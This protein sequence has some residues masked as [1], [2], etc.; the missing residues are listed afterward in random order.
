MFLFEIQSATDQYDRLPALAKSLVDHHVSVIVANDV[1]ATYAAKAATSTIPIVFESGIDPVK[2]GLVA[3]LNH[4]GTT[5]W[6]FT[7]PDTQGHQ[8][9]RLACRPVDEVLAGHQPQDRESVRLDDPTVCPT[10]AS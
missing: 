8:A 10:S 5:G 4:P 6:A 2:G 3:S 7:R 9:H 1:V